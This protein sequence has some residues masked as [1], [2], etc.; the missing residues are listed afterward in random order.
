MR[1]LSSTLSTDTE[2]ENDGTDNS[3]SDDDDGGVQTIFAVMDGCVIDALDVRTGGCLS[4]DSLKREICAAC[5]D[6]TDGLGVENL[7][8]E[9]KDEESGLGVVVDSN[10]ENDED[11]LL[12]ACKACSTLKATF[13]NGRR[14]YDVQHEAS[15]RERI[16]EEAARRE[17]EREACREAEERA[18]RTPDA[19]RILPDEAA[20]R[21]PP[22]LPADY[23]D[24]GGKRSLEVDRA[25]R[26]GEENL[27]QVLGVERGASHDEIRR[28]YLRSGRAAHP[29]KNPHD[30]A[31]ATAAQQ[32]INLAYNV[33]LDPSLLAIHEIRMV[34][35]RRDAKRA[36]NRATRAQ[37]WKAHGQS[38]DQRRR[39]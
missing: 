11:A 24:G 13:K 8:L 26:W 4:I 32:M 33:L 23:S 9:Y 12:E 19:G 39:R 28:A 30:V 34:Q 16:W 37:L 15:I 38:S 17:L 10:S 14:A 36:A 22:P 3:S 18:R 2:D 7:T 6:L 35:R 27:W 21:Q 31:A 1:L 25:L 5:W 20:S 29:D